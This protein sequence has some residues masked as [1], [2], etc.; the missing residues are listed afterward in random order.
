[1]EEPIQCGFPHHY[2]RSFQCNT[3]DLIICYHEHLHWIVIVS[4][5]TVASVSTSSNL[6]VVP[7]VYVW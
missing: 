7:K 2:Y 1:M 5:S 6:Q 4:Y 3:L